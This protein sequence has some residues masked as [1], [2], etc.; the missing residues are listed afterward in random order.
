MT[1]CDNPKCTHGK[2]EHLLGELNC[3]HIMDKIPQFDT[4]IIPRDQDGN[5]CPINAYVLCDC[6]QFIEP[7]I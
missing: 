6:K 3:T 1:L 7:K 5:P 2:E 4:P